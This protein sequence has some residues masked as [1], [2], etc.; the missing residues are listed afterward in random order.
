MMEISYSNKMATNPITGDLTSKEVGPLLFE[1][2]K[3]QKN[4]EIK[5]TA[6]EII[7]QC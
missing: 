5:L 6:Q 7:D 2:M 4:K 3:N 1:I